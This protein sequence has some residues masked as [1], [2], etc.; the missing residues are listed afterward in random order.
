M[1]CF[2]RP[3]EGEGVV[4]GVFSGGVGFVIYSQILQLLAKSFSLSTAEKVLFCIDNEG[5]REFFGYMLNR[6]HAFFV[7]ESF[8][9]FWCNACI[10]KGNAFGKVEKNLLL[11]SKAHII[12]TA[13]EKGGAKPCLRICLIKFLQ[14]GRVLQY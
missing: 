8:N 13:V 9:L 14:E 3:S 10:V 5:F 2:A 7:L 4:V 12:N 1:R 6:G 11:E